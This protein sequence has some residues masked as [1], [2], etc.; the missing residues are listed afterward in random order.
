MNDNLASEK[1]AQ[2]W[3]D[4][5]ISLIEAPIYDEKRALHCVKRWSLQCGAEGLNVNDFVFR[6]AGSSLTNALPQCVIFKAVLSKG[7]AIRESGPSISTQ[8]IETLILAIWDEGVHVDNINTET[9]YENAGVMEWTL[10]Q[11]ACSNGFRALVKT[12]LKRGASVGPSPRSGE[13]ALM[14]AALGGHQDLVKLLVSAGSDI[15]I[16]CLRYKM[17]ALLF[18]VES[19]PG[20]AKLLIDL[21]AEVNQRDETGDYALLKAARFNDLEQVKDLIESGSELD[22]QNEMGE[23]PCHSAADFNQLDNLKCLIEAGANFQLQDKKGS[24]PLMVAKNKGHHEI[25]MYLE[26]VEQALKDQLTLEQALPKVKMSKSLAHA[27][28][29]RI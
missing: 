6:E 17:T 14:Y 19:L 29:K 4:E 15:N 18:A 10:L 2:Q 1:T 25:V 24:T 9:K 12:S 21:G 28:K 5:L 16:Q 22:L 23:T 27:A 7:S 20:M 8:N 13:T 11:A 26:G 3:A